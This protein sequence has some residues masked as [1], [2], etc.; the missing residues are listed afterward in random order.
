MI[1]LVVGP[2]HDYL[3]HLRCDFIAKVEAAGGRVVVPE[4]DDELQID[5]DGPECLTRFNSV[6]PMLA[7]KLGAFVIDR[8]SSRSGPPHEHITLAVNRPLSELERVALQAIAGSDPRRELFGFLRIASG[9]EMP[10][11]FAEYEPVWETA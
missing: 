5:I 1:A 8:H 2:D 4:S 10:T 6:F 11:A 9:V 3:E 7:D